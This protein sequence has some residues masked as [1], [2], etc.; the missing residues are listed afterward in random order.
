MDLRRTAIGRMGISRPSSI[1]LKGGGAKSTLWASIA[2]EVFGA[3]LAL[4][5]RSAAGRALDVAGVAA[6]WWTFEDTAARTFQLPR[7]PEP[8]AVDSYAEHFSRYVKL[9]GALESA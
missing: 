2:A 8:A 6:G 7:E 4:S 9:V 3:P 1:V 5:S